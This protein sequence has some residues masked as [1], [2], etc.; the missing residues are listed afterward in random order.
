MHLFLKRLRPARR[1]S[2][3]IHAWMVDFRPEILNYISRTN[4]QT[5]IRQQ[6]AQFGWHG[7]IRLEK[8]LMHGYR[9]SAK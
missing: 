3:R 5:P 7:K 4:P 6:R 2:Q 1:G 9:H 8:L